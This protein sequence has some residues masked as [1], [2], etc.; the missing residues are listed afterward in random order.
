MNIA[1]RKRLKAKRTPWSKT[2]SGRRAHARADVMRAM[3][4]AQGLSNIKAINSQLVSDKLVKLKKACA[5][6]KAAILAF[7]A[8][9]SVPVYGSKTV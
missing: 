9:A 7:N 2:R 8:A 4:L 6:T 3:V 5:T 1:K